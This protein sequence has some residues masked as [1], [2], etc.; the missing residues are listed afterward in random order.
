MI[1]IPRRIL[2]QVLTHAAEG[3]PDEVCGLL[4]AE[5]GRVVEAVRARNAAAEPRTRYEVH[6]EDLLAVFRIEERGQDLGV[7]HSH[8]LSVP[9]PS[10]TDV[11]QAELWPGIFHLI[12]SHRHPGRPEAHVYRIDDGGIAEEEVRIV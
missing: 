9:Y 8:P 11:K 2:D 10:C 3:A 4:A 12:V 5:R 7:Y 1:E 6:T